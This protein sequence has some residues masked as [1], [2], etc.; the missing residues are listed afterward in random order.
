MWLYRWLLRLSPDSLRREYGAAME[1]M[2]ARRLI[3]M[4]HANI[5]HRARLC[6]REVEGLVVLAG[7]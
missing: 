5:A 2:F 7:S 3:E 6:G 4:R 1:E